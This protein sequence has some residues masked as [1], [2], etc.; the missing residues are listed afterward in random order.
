MTRDDF[1]R[2]LRHRFPGATESQYMAALLDADEY[3]AFTA[4]RAARQPEW[5]VTEK[6]TA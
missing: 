6:R 5:R 1:L 2:L 3:A 4:E